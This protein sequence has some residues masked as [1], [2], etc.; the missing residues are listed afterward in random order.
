VTNTEVG[1]WQ[2]FCSSLIA[3]ATKTLKLN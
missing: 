2:F 1:K 3:T